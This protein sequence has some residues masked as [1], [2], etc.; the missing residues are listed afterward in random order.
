[1]A[2]VWPKTIA[3]VFMRKNTT[4]LPDREFEGPIS[5]KA[6]DAVKNYMHKNNSSN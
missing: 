1:M 4:E 2:T 6:R 3:V 5:R